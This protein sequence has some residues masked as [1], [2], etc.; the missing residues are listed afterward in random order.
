MDRIVGLSII[1]W[2]LILLLR[3]HEMLLFLQTSLES[4]LV[5]TAKEWSANFKQWQRPHRLIGGTLLESNCGIL[6]SS[7]L[8]LSVNLKI[9][10]GSLLMVYFSLQ[11]IILNVRCE[12][13]AVLLKQCRSSIQSR[14]AILTLDKQYDWNLFTTKF[15]RFYLSSPGR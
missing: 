12:R 13:Y 1:Y 4:E 10:M 3:M 2:R 11:F 5:F 14:T 9:Q 7:G 8:K 15:Y 6:I